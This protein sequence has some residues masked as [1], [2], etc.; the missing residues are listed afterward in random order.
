MNLRLEH[1]TKPAIMRLLVSLFVIFLSFTSLNAQNSFFDAL[2]SGDA[3]KVTQL[4]DNNVELCFDDKVSFLDRTKANNRLRTFFTD[5]PPK[6]LAQV[7]KGDSP[8]ASSKYLIANYTSTK[9]KRFRVYIFTKKGKSGQKI[10]EL[11]FDSL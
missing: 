1:Q 11:R 3:D 2:R 5:H 6:A 7:H 4:M 10:Q 8:G 9:G